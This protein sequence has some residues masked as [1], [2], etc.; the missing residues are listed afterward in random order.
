M[1]DFQT[2]TT[3]VGRKQDTRWRASQHANDVARPG[4]LNPTLFTAGTH[5]NLNGATD[6]VIPSGVAVGQVTATKLY[7]P[8]DA[9]ATDGRQ[10]LAGFI[11]D[12]QGVEL[13]ATPATAKP[14]FAL[15]VHALI[16]ASVLPIAAQRTAVKTATASGSFIYVED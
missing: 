10:T 3:K 5:Y 14:T 15:L 12:N 1:V 6:N 9:T 8:Y 2:T 13:G 11:N 4:Q 7:G 16:K